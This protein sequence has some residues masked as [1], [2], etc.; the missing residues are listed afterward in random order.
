MNKRE[1][2]N[3]WFVRI[4]TNSRNKPQT[5]NIK[6]N[7]FGNLDLCQIPSQITDLLLYV[8]KLIKKLFL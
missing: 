8:L 4:V 7:N 3:F 6:I 2:L 1:A 5:K